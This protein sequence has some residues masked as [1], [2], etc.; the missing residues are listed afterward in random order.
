[1]LYY[2]FMKTD[3]IDISLLFKNTLFSYFYYF[4]YNKIIYKTQ[5]DI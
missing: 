3:I 4:F 1:M 5:N 2:L